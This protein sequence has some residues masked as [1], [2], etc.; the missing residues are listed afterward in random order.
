MKITLINIPFIYLNNDNIRHSQ[1]LGSR[2]ISSYLKQKGFHDI[3][4]IDALHEGFSVVKPY[5]GGYVR[6]LETTGIVNLIT[7]DT[8]LVGISVPF[9]QLAPLAHN[10]AAGIKRKF[11]HVRVIMGG[12]YPSTSPEH[13]LNSSA[14]IIAVGEGEETFLQLARGIPAS[15]IQGVYD[16]T[17]I[18]RIK[19]M[20]QAR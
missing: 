18:S 16:R 10:I 7:S 2:Y 14:D 11:P 20:Q 1:C 8:E 4:F 13:A 3:T 15:N 12:V 17:Q 6:G 5:A 9:S 19:R